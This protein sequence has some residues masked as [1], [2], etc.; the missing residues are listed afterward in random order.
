M[1]C[2]TLFLTRCTFLS[3][4]INFC[5]RIRPRL[6]IPSRVFSG[7]ACASSLKLGRPYSSSVHRRE[8]LRHGDYPKRQQQITVLEF[9]DNDRG[10]FLSKHQKWSQRVKEVAFGARERICSVSVRHYANDVA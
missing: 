8:K 1:R 5:D 10:I 4:I 7:F 9:H 6:P 2:I 3:T